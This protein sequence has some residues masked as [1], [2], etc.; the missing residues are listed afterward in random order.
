MRISRAAA[1]SKSRQEFLD[2]CL[3]QS[4]GSGLNIS[5]TPEKYFHDWL[6]AKEQLGRT[7]A[8]TLTRYAPILERFVAFLPDIRR[9]SPLASITASDV[10]GFLPPKKTGDYRIVQQTPACGCFPLFSIPP[11]A[12]A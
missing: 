2:E 4:G 3:R 7:S 8:S 9:R 11:G 5:P 6:A 10:E 1:G 12:K